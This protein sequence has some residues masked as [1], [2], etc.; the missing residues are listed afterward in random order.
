[1]SQNVL[2]RSHHYQLRSWLFSGI[3]VLVYLTNDSREP[4]GSI[5]CHSLLMMRVL[6]FMTQIFVT[7]IGC[8]DERRKNDNKM[9]VC[10]LHLFYRTS[11]ELL[12]TPVVISRNEKERVLIEGSVNSLRISIAIKQ[13][14]YNVS[15]SCICCRSVRSG[16]IIACRCSNK[17]R[18]R[19]HVWV[20]GWIYNACK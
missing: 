16:V 9:F 4:H 13:V 8:R 19:H 6:I 17:C 10:I 2:L 12:L 18:L 14:R 1:M 3:S 15:Y 11:R 20:Y 5:V 7:S